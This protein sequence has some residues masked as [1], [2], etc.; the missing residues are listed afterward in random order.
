MSL[1]REHLKRDDKPI[2]IFD[3]GTGTSFQNMNLTS[4]DFG[5]EDLEGC[6]ENLV[7]SSPASVEEVHN[8][9]LEAGCDI[10]ETNTFGASSIVLDEYNISDKAYEINY[11]ASIIAKR[12][13]NKYSSTD[14]PKFV[15]GSIG[16]TTKLPT[17]GH[18]SFDDL[19]NSYK[20]QISG[21]IDGGCDLLLIETCQDVYRSNQ[22]FSQPRKY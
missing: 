16:P 3:G 10:I 8:T 6:N 19:K 9:F 7:L 15:A 13:A 20:D 1:F 2:I 21:L 22:H 14:N 12:C 17:L 4:S 18:I 5:G 11:K